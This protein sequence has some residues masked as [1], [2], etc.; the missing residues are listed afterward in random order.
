MA[1]QADYER[2][3]ADMETRKQAL[4]ERTAALDRAKKEV[5]LHCPHPAMLTGETRVPEHISS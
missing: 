1:P 3:L 4:R 5:V 2:M